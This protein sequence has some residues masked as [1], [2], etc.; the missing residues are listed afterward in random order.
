M[1]R[2]LPSLAGGTA[3]VVSPVSVLVQ[4]PS[5]PEKLGRGHFETSCNESVTG[6]VYPA[7]ALLHSCEF[8]PAIAGFEQVLKADPSCGIAAWGIA[9]SVWGNPF[10]GLRAPR[11]IQDGQ[12]AAE[13]AQ[14]IGTKTS[15]EREYI[16]AVAL[17][18]RNAAA[19]DQ[20]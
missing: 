9:M 3:V 12:A 13:R 2:F 17:L 15:R 1:R 14:T 11:V 10:S 6:A 4:S 7:V 8:P 16:D 5:A 20:R 19:S 18:Y